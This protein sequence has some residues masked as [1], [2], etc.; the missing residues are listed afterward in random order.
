MA[1]LLPVLE[2]RSTDCRSRFDKRSG[3]GEE[4]VKKVVPRLYRWCGRLDQSIPGRSSHM[5]ISW[6]IPSEGHAVRLRL[7]LVLKNQ[8]Y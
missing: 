3:D 1:R 4:A 2:V 5:R 7:V 6:S 8:L